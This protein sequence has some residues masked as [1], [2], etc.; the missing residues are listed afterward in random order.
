[1]SQREIMVI[2]E[3]PDIGKRFGR[4][5]VIRKAKSYRSPGGSTK[6]R[7]YCK[8]DCGQRVVVNVGHLR[9]GKIVSCGCRMREPKPHHGYSGTPTYRS[10]CAMK[11]RCLYKRSPKYH[12]YGGRGIRVCNRWLRF[13]NFLKDMGERPRGKTLDRKNNNLGYF[14]KNCRWATAAEQ[15]NNQRGR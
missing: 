1:M 4:L 2:G 13:E 3:H 7:L 15:R 10:W 11:Q 8:C 9:S 12:L 14:K 5:V 6:A